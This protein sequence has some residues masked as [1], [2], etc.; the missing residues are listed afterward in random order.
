MEDKKVYKLNT[1]LILNP[2]SLTLFDITEFKELCVSNLDGCKTIEIN[3][4]KTK[5]V[6]IS[7]FQF[8]KSLEN[9][10]ELNG[11]EIKIL[12]TPDL[13]KTKFENIGVSL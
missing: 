10:C 3:L 9:Y 8:I 5:E 2:I 4:E 11:L 1:A 7:G 6:D 12:N 13:I